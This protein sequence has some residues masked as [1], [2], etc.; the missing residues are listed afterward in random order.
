MNTTDKHSFIDGALTTI[1]EKATVFGSAAQLVQR[2][3]YDHPCSRML[4][5][6]RDLVRELKDKTQSD[7][8]NGTSLVANMAVKP[9]VILGLCQR[10]MNQACWNARRY[11]AISEQVELDEEFIS[12][13]DWSEDTAVEVGIE[14]MDTAHIGEAIESDFR[15]L[16]KL[17]S[18]IAGTMPNLQNVEDFHLY[19]DS[20]NED[21]QWRIVRSADTFDD[22]LALMA[23]IV[24]ELA[25]RQEAALSE[26][27]ETQDWDDNEEQ[28]SDAPVAAA[29]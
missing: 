7:E 15:Q 28:T 1:S 4:A 18:V 23:D 24:S 29:S 14:P 27:V 25:E 8:I 26:L 5:T 21:E 6:Y 16:C 12:Q 11:K 17:H 19:A 20:Q 3:D 9:G 10:V 2:Q 13:A 22:A